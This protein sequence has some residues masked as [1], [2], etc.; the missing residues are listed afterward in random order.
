[1]REICENPYIPNIKPRFGEYTLNSYLFGEFVTEKTV[2]AKTLLTAVREL[3]SALGF[4]MAYM[5][6]EFLAKLVAYSVTESDYDTDNI[7]SRLAALYEVDEAIIRD[8]INAVLNIN[9]NF[10]RRAAKLLRRDIEPSECKNTVTAIMM[11]D[12]VFKIYY[13]YKA[14]S[15]SIADEI[16][17][18]NYLKVILNGK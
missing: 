4:E 7:I 16:H 10:Q 13:N 11:I 6:Y 17:T 9:G 8:N 1:M 3:L 14:I 15:G 2:D 12:A 5:G 18:V